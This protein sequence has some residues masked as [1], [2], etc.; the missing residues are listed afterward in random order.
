[1]LP[2]SERTPGQHFFEQ[3]AQ[4]ECAF[5]VFQV[6]DADDHCGG[7][8]CAGFEPLGDVER[9]AFT[10]AG[11]AGRGEQGVECGGE[12]FALALGA[13]GDHAHF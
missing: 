6:G 13:G 7:A 10:P 4:D 3:Y 5:F 8:A 9:G 1:L 11:E 2:G 12:G